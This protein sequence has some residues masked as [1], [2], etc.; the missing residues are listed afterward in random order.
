M[1]RCHTFYGH[2]LMGGA[3]GGTSCEIPFSAKKNIY[4][5]PGDGKLRFPGGCRSYLCKMLTISAT[6][7]VWAGAGMMA[8]TH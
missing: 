3:Y 7:Y 2:K 6:Y 4:T 1:E 8:L 5:N